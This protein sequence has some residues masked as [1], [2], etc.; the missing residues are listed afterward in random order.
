MEK[1][2]H[3]AQEVLGDSKACQDKPEILEDKVFSLK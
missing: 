1:E 3:L 2:D